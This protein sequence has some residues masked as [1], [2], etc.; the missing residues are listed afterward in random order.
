MSQPS[1]VLLLS[2]GRVSVPMAPTASRGFVDPWV[3]ETQEEAGVA[4][5]MP[6]G[7]R[8]VTLMATITSANRC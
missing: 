1:G 3:T 7:A 6:T 4:T 5:L 8:Q 2:V